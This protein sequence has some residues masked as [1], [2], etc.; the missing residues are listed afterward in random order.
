[1]PLIPPRSLLPSSSPRRSSPRRSPPATAEPCASSS[2]PRALVDIT[3]PIDASLVTFEKADGLGPQH[4]RESSSRRG[5]PRERL[6]ARLRR[7]HRHARGRSATLL[8]EG[9]ARVETIPL[10]TINGPA[11]VVDAFGVPLLDAEA[12][13][14]I[15]ESIPDSPAVSRVIFRTD[16]TRRDLM[17]KTPFAEDYVGFS[18]DGAEWMVKK[19]PSIEAVGVDYVSVA[20]SRTWS[21][22]TSSCSTQGKLPIEGLVV[23]ERRS[24]RGGGTCTAPRSKSWE[25][26]TAPARRG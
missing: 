4:R 1:M 20:M 21:P 9:R 12:L 23:P 14:A 3:A 16:N 19:R 26:T 25:A 11:L 7:A 18:K 22:R 15:A 2:S 5:R 13:E 6:R 17:R 8:E 10:A 24:P